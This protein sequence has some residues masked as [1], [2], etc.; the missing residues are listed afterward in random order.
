MEPLN[1]LLER[2]AERYGLRDVYVF[3]SRAK[4]M[5]AR[6]KG[7][8]PP[9]T[10]PAADV[11]VAVQPRSG[12]V[13]DARDRVRLATE[14][15]DLFDAPRVDLVILSEARP[16]LAVEVVRGELLYTADPRA[17]A[18]HELYILRRA[19]DLAPFQ[20]ERVREILAGGAR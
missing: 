17:Q 6:V 5:A 10:Q 20:R 4:E 7:I 2:I 14:L 16:F 8:S 3:G 12:R 15:E 11:D 19:A 9:E 13:P 18:E 1:V